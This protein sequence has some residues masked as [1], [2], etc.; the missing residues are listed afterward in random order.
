MKL[1]TYRLPTGRHAQHVGVADGDRVVDLTAAVALLREGDHSP[2]RAARLAEVEAPGDLSAFLREP[3]ALDVLHAAI[4]A[5]VDS[6]ATVTGTGR[7][8]T[9]A[10]ADVELLAPVPRP[11]GMACFTLWTQH[12][13]DSIG[14]GFTLGLP[15][16][17]SDVLGYYKANP[18]AVAGPGQPVVWP[19][20]T[21]EFDFEC[22]LAAVVGRSVKDVTPEEAEKAILGY[23]IFN[24]FS[25]RDVQREEMR[26]GLG[27]TKGKDMDGSNVLGPWIV[28]PD[29]VGSVR[30]LTMSVHV[31]G[32]QWSE[33]HTGIMEHT[34]GELLS[35]LSRG[36]T[37]HPGQV[38]TSGCYPGGSGLD[39][40]RQVRPGDEV[41]LRI[42]RLGSLRNRIVEDTAAVSTTP[43]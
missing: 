5:G 16:E 20:Y 6:G 32:E 33:C 18:D 43:G 19:W 14:K 1:V 21:E 42:T 25:A 8:V 23:T 9:R 11:P 12:L 26:L 31:D 39:L 40:G 13:A 41:E 2:G 30:A 3:Q 34:F 10:L 7:P 22:E 15:E 29:E 36:Q 27:P 38:L 17:G 4:A 35:Y 28:T 24:D 37:V